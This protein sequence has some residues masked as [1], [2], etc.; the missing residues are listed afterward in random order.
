ME[1]ISRRNNERGTELNFVFKEGL[2][3]E[4][5]IRLPTR[6][7]EIEEQE[8]GILTLSREKLL[9]TFKIEHVKQKTKKTLS[10]GKNC[11]KQ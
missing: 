7:S 4:I 6:C 10:N 5:K 8:Q 2:T 1:K 3:F 11:A 9:Y